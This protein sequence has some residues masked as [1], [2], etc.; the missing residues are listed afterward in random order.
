MPDEPDDK[1]D[2]KDEGPGK[3]REAIDAAVRAAIDWDAPPPGDPKVSAAFLLGWRVALATGG[4]D[5]TGFDLDAT[6]F[7][8][9]LRAQ[10]E[11][12]AKEL[13]GDAAPDVPAE[14]DPAFRA[15]MVTALAIKDPVLGRAGQIGVAL[16]RFCA[17]DATVAIPALRKDLSV[18]ATK[19]PP[20]AAHTVMNSLT[21]WEGVTDRA[22]AR[23][24]AQGD[25]WR[26][27]LA[28][29]TAPKDLLHLNDYVGTAASVVSRL[30]EVAKCAFR[31]RL[32]LLLLAVLVLFG[33]GLFLLASNDDTGTNLAGVSSV[34]AAFGLTW[35]GIGTSLGRA[36]AKAER[37]LWN[38]QLNW[39]IAYRATIPGEQVKAAGG[40]KRRARHLKEWEQWRRKWPDFEMET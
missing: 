22:P 37:A 31:G 1:T 23:L 36:A 29:E 34:L 18:L 14:L 40:T 7:R 38:S 16:Q 9:V 11:G 3:P 2:E 33:A 13:L 19:F 26:P 30:G 17:N 8:N 24:E 21:L 28:G 39:V 10:I 5:A 20:Y 32:G 12:A 35:K 15:T 6:A 25:V 27:L 4:T